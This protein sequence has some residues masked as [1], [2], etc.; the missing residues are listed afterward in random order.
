VC[1]G[2]CGDLVQCLFNESRLHSYCPLT[3]NGVTKVGV[4]RWWWWWWWCHL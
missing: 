4:T 2:V 3:R 1:H